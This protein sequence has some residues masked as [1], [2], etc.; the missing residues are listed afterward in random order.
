MLYNEWLSSCHP[1]G[2]TLLIL[3]FITNYPI[4]KTFFNWSNLTESRLSKENK[5]LASRQFAINQDYQKRRN[6]WQN[7]N[8]NLTLSIK[9]KLGDIFLGGSI[10]PCTLQ[11]SSSHLV[12]VQVFAWLNS[13]KGDLY[14]FHWHCCACGAIY[15]KLIYCLDNTWVWSQQ[16]LAILSGFKF[17]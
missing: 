12:V 17:W 9:S 1:C 7:I 3:L 15:S 5:H 2:P 10:P 4:R 6:I 16:H 14:R 13:Y 11:C 8:Y